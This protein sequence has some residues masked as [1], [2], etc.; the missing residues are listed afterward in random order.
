MTKRVSTE[1]DTVWI[2]RIR[3]YDNPYLKR[4]V[5]YNETSVLRGEI[6]ETKK[7]LLVRWKEKHG[8]VKNLVCYIGLFRPSEAA[9]VMAK[10]MIQAKE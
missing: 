4:W 3:D 6:K 2:L 7:K 8:T 10:N 1:P 9:C 5:L